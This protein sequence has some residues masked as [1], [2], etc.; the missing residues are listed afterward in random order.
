MATPERLHTKSRERVHTEAEEPCKKKQ[1]QRTLSISYD[2]DAS[3]IVDTLNL[4]SS[5]SGPIFDA[6]SRM[7]P[8]Q[9]PMHTDFL[10]QSKSGPSL[11]GPALSS[12]AETSPV[13]IALVSS[14]PQ[15]F[16]GANAAAKRGPAGGKGFSE[17]SMEEVVL[18][19]MRIDQESV[20]RPGFASPAGAAKPQGS[21][22]AWEDGEVTEKVTS[23]EGGAT[24]TSFENRPL[25]APQQ[26]A[27]NE[28]TSQIRVGLAPRDV[29]PSMM[30]RGGVALLARN[31]SPGNGSRNSGLPPRGLPVTG[32]KTP[33]LP[34]STSPGLPRSQSPGEGA[35]KVIQRSSTP[36]YSAAPKPESAGLPRR[37]KVRDGFFLCVTVAFDVELR[38]DLL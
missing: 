3:P 5:A 21:G 26:E 17:D 32:A 9:S 18:E 25:T 15:G 14:K 36:P 24:L 10:D 11:L 4:E 31:P 35:G 22:G 29:S 34:R 12:P 7:A 1:R 20:A 2:D 13:N 6:S 16:E 33:G 23:L 38:R 28:I 19:M 8:D 37:A 30:R 27:V